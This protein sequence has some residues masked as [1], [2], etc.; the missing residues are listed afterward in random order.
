MT[1]D[2][3]VQ[4][5]SWSSVEFVTA[6]ACDFLSDA[7]HCLLTVCYRSTLLVVRGIPIQHFVM[8]PSLMSV[9]PGF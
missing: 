1:V 6:L 5:L 9:G 7:D 4:C 2:V 3:I 8:T